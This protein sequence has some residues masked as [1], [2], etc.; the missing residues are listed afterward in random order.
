[1]KFEVFVPILPERSLSPNSRVHW[2][3]S[4]HAKKR[5]MDFVATFAAH[6]FRGDPI[7]PAVLDVELRVC[8]NRPPP[9]DNYYRPK[10]ADNGLAALKAAIDGLVW[11]GVLADDTRAHMKLRNVEL[12]D[13]PSH[14]D[15]GIHF[16]VTLR[17]D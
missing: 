3:K 10:D 14:A 7:D 11:A 5:L 6:H 1:M 16:V 12:V 17:E 8:R 2:S 13:V 4:A 9:G 15:E